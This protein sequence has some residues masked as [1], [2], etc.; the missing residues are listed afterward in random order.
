MFFRKKKPRQA[1]D[2]QARLRQLQL[3]RAKAED[4]RRSD[5]RNYSLSGMKLVTV[6][7][8]LQALQAIQG[9]QELLPKDEAAKSRYK[10]P[11][12]SQERARQREWLMFK[13]DWLE[14]ILEDTV[15]EI[16]AIDAWEHEHPDDETQEQAKRL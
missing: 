1:E 13:A 7:N 12:D 3:D 14:A 9:I 6:L 11:E 4:K 10:I 15:H 2:Y 8:Q 16:E 5:G